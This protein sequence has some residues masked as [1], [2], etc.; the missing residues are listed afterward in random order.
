MIHL[1]HSARL[2]TVHADIHGRFHSLLSAFAAET[3]C[4]VLVNTSFNVRGEP[5]VCTPEDAFH[6]FMG[7]GIDTLA[8]GTAC[9]VN[10]IRIRPWPSPGGS[11]RIDARAGARHQK[12]K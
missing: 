3:G 11:P 4:P 7:T 12:S 2:Q 1:D 6:C 9:C 10:P 8:I 5:V